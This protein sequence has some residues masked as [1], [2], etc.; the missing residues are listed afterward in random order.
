MLLNHSSS[1]TAK[2]VH[3]ERYQEYD[4]ISMSSNELR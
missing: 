4:L 3:D 1:S 2:Q